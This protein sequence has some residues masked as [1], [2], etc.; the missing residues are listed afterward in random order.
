MITVRSV[1]CR[2]RS[3]RAALRPVSS[4]FPG[5]DTFARR[6]IGPQEKDIDAML[7]VV[8]AS[9]LD[10]LTDKIVPSNIK[11]QRKL[12]EEPALTESELLSDLRELGSKNKQYRTFIGQGY[13]GTKTPSVIIR[14]LLESPGWYTSYT[15]YQA[16]I[17]QG[18][19]ESLL[20]FQTVVCDLTALPVANASLLDEA[21]AVG[22]TVGIALTHGKFKKTKYFLDGRNKG[23]I[24]S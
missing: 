23:W 19:L 10:E 22:E 15:P 18:R 20:N 6:H 14:N 17:A 11:I 1:V 16:E 5:T 4:T 8:G 24:H 13:Y 7:K 3:L 21:T 12:W 2:A 9:T